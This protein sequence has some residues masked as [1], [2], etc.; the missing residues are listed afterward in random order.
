MRRIAFLCLTVAALVASSQPSWAWGG[1]GHRIVAAIAMQ[2]IPKKAAKLDIVLRQLE[3]DNN[4]IDAASY[5]DEYV[6]SHDREHAMSPWHFADLPDDNTPFV[7]NNCLFDALGKNLDI[8]SQ[9]RG[10]KENAQ[11]ISW[12]IHLVGDMH[13]PLHMDGRLRGG[14]DFPVTYRGKKTCKSYSGRPTKVEL[15]SVWDDCLVEEL[16]AGRSPQQMA[17]ALLGKIRSHKG[18]PEVA[19]T[20]PKPWLEWSGE[21]HDLAVKVAFADLQAGTDL[22]APYI[23]GK[24]HAI[25]IV[26][27]QLLTA[28]IRLAFLL[29]RATK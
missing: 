12:V 17:K 1:R 2:L 14:N 6:R 4:F 13:Q 24:G 21:I 28:G 25:D 18:R 9:N 22:G 27:Q 10:D 8:V 16:S 3:I 5:P 15:H 26:R 29:D 23:E 7:C 19:G 11:A 20:D